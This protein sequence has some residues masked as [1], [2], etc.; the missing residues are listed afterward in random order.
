MDGLEGL[1]QDISSIFSPFLLLLESFIPGSNV[2]EVLVVVFD[3]FVDQMTR[4][5]YCNNSRRIIQGLVSVSN[6]YDCGLR[7]PPNSNIAVCRI[8]KAKESQSE[9]YHLWN[10]EFQ[11]P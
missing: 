8:F 9:V 10:S 3:T 6:P 1:F 7:L 2:S 11:G 4:F 5:R